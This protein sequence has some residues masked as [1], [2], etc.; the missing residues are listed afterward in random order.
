MLA[1][2]IEFLRKRSGW[3]NQFFNRYLN[4][5]LKTDEMDGIWTGATWVFLGSL[6]TIVVFPKPLAILAL[7]YMCFGDTVAALVGKAW[8]RLR[9]GEKSLEGF[10]S[11]LAVCFVIAW[12]FP[13][14]SWPVR[15]IG[16]IMAMSVEILPIPI[17]DN[18]RI[19]VF[20]GAA[21]T[22]AGMVGL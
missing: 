14:L 6:I 17:D 7:L 13:E 2:V 11:G 20:S 19:P 21:M 18:L 8:G 3:I 10:L 22:L 9:F 1:L 12:F 5:M 15:S 16:A 4:F